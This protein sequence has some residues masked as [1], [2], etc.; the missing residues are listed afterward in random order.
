MSEDRFGTNGCIKTAGKRGQCCAIAYGF[1]L[2]AQ[3]GMA[4]ELLNSFSA[5]QI[6]C[7]RC[8]VHLCCIICYSSWNDTQ[9]YT[10]YDTLFYLVSSVTG[11][12]S[13]VSTSATL[14][15]LQ[16]GDSTALELGATVIFTALLG[17]CFLSERVNKLDYVILLA[18]VIG[19]ILICKPEFLF[20]NKSVITEES[21]QTIYGSLIALLAGFFV[22]IWSLFVKK[23]SNKGTLNLML[24]MFFQGI[25][26]VPICLLLSFFFDSWTTPSSMKAWLLLSTFGFTCLLQG[27]VQAIALGSEDVKTVAISSTISTV[28]TYVIQLAIFRA[29]FDIVI[30]FGA[31]IITVTMVIMHII[32]SLPEEQ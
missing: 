13:W 22:S 15:Y 28:L 16:V 8:L 3:L 27:L 32:R 9:R 5:I 29:S 1:I 31:T 23:L 19:I 20:G 14:Y 2:A 18:D 21:T 30:T 6:T 17:H 4:K 10:G 26:G 24:L 7:I 12:L 11:C 25:G